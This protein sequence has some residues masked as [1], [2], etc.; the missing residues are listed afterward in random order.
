MSILVLSIGSETC[1][2]EA[3]ISITGL[4]SKDINEKTTR[5]PAILVGIKNSDLAFFTSMH[6]IAQIIPM[7]HIFKL[8]LKAQTHP[9]FH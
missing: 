6:N 9:L 4:I 8:S 2:K 7:A 5:M 1:I 3:S